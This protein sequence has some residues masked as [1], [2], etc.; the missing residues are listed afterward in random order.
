MKKINLLYAGITFFLCLNLI[1][2][3][4]HVRVLDYLNFVIMILF[5]VLLLIQ[6]RKS[7]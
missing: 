6:D 5:F 4:G 7:L 3:T 2:L 1:E